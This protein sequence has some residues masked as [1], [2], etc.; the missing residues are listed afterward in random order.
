MEYQ[1][2]LD[3]RR[4]GIAKIIADGYQRLTHGDVLSAEEDSLEARIGRGEG[5]QTEF[6]STLR[7]N[8]HTG[9]NDP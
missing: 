8:V 4:N 3:V 6:K 5:M 2:F 9:Q 1:D 7:V